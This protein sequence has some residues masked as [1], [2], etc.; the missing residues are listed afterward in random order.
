MISACSS[1]RRARAAAVAPPYSSANDP[2]NVAAFVAQNDRSGFSPLVTPAG[3]R[4]ELA[5]AEPPV[6][7]DVRTAKEFGAGHLP[8]AVNV[9]VDDLRDESVRAGYIRPLRGRRVIVYCKGGFRGHLAVRILKEQGITD[10]ANV[11]GGWTSMRLE[12]ELPVARAE[13]AALAAH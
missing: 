1:S 7:V 9:P 12:G 4:A 5:G 8:G 3:L 10:V 13:E 2:V 11:T 6:V